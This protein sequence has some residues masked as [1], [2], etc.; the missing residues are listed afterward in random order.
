MNLTDIFIDISSM[1]EEKEE[2]ENQRIIK[3]K[4]KYKRRK[5]D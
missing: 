1:E 4:I 5:Y 3:N 2:K